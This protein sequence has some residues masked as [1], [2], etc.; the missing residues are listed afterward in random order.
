MG[1]ASLALPPMTTEPARAL[2]YLW[3]MPCR[4]SGVNARVLRRKTSFIDAEVATVIKN[5][6]DAVEP[7]CP[8]HAECGGCP[9]QTMPYAQQLFWKRTLAVDA[10]T[11]I[12]KFDRAQVE[13]MLPPVTGVAR[14]DVVSQ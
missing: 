5:A 14:A 6:P 10:L 12:G 7:I 3:Q 8:H 9:L 1:A 13:S 4:A 11:R 2:S